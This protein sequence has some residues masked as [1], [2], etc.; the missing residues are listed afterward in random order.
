MHAMLVSLIDAFPA[1]I[2]A[3]TATVTAA[4][5]ITALTPSR[6]DDAVLDITLRFLNLLAGNVGHNRNA[7]DY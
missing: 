3:L 7:D 1:W 5:A 6:S 4:T 2:A